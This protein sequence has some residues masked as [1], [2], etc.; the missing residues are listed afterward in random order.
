M[1][2]Q[3]FVRPMIFSPLSHNS[4]QVGV[5]VLPDTGVTYM[6]AADISHCRV[7]HA[8]DY[9]HKAH[10]KPGLMCTGECTVNG[11]SIAPRGRASQVE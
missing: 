1:C 10:Q 5:Q 6:A 9:L 3:R 8:S 4:D 11:L 7:I 2:S